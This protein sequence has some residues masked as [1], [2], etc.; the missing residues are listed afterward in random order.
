MEPEESRTDAAI[1]SA[2]LDGIAG[3]IDN[4]VPLTAKALPSEDDDV[5]RLAKEAWKAAASI[6]ARAR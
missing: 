1:I 4:L 2:A 3:I 6:R 5:A